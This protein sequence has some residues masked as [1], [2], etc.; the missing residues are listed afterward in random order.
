[1]TYDLTEIRNISSL[2]TRTEE[3]LEAQEMGEHI[4]AE[5]VSELLKDCAEFFRGVAGG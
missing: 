5:D 1:M 3:I 4:S 2:Q